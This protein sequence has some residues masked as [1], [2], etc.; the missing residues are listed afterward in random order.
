M[1]G[2]QASGARQEA[3]VAV[4]PPALLR[5]GKAWSH[6]THDPGYDGHQ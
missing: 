2:E 5:T 4:V 3:E 6:A 1:R